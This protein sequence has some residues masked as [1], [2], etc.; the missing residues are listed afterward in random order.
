MNGNV[1]FGNLSK[2]DFHHVTLGFEDG[3]WVEEHK[4]ILAASAWQKQAS[5]D[6][7]EGNSEQGSRLMENLLYFYF[8]GF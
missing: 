3:K 2:K 5:A 1:H 4:M 7:Y 6:I 8:K